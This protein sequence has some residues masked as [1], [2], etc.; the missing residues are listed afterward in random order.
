MLSIANSVY[1]T[2]YK[3]HCV[4]KFLPE[5]QSSVPNCGCIFSSVIAKENGKITAIF[6]RLLCNQFALHESHKAK[7]KAVPLQARRSPEYSKKL[8]FPDFV[9]AAQ[10]GGRL[11]ALRTGLPYPQ[12]MLLVFISVRGWV[13][14]RAIVRSEGLCQWKIPMTPSGIETATFMKAIPYKN[15]YLPEDS[16][17]NVA[18]TSRVVCVPYCWH[19]FHKPIA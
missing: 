18:L 5:R 8:R 13:D 11:S 2:R 3:R 12:E 15:L 7:G 1:R 14:P 4:E 10:D 9:T 17:S 6:V 16:D 19:W